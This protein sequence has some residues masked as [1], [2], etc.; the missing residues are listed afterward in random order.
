MLRCG[1]LLWFPSAG[2][3]VGKAFC[4][5]S[6]SLSSLCPSLVWRYALFIEFSRRRFRR[7]LLATTV[8][9]LELPCYGPCVWLLQSQELCGAAM[10]SL[11][12]MP[13]ELWTF[14]RCLFA[15]RSRLS[16][17]LGPRGGTSAEPQREQPCQPVLTFLFGSFPYSCLLL[18]VNAKAWAKQRGRSFSYLGS[19]D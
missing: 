2:L 13:K 14:N 10:V 19:D 7:E 11:E 12:C 8:S 17:G 16:S 4:S 5:L 18:L 6:F 9:V 15:F 3:T 1:F